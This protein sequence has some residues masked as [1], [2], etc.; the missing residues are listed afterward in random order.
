MLL[1]C[2]KTISGKIIAK[3]LSHF[4]E[5]SNMLHNEQIKDRKNRSTIDA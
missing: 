4:V 5:H 3:R 1:N 2:L